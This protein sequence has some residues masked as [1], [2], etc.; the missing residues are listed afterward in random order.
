MTTGNYFQ[1]SGPAAGGQRSTGWAPPNPNPHQYIPGQGGYP[2][3]PYVT[4]RGHGV[5]GYHGAVWYPRP[6]AG[7]TDRFAFRP[8]QFQ[9]WHPV[10][11]GDYLVDE[12]GRVTYAPDYYRSAN[13]TFA[14]PESNALWSRLPPADRVYLYSWDDLLSRSEWVQAMA[15]GNI[16]RADQIKQD[17][18]SRH[19]AA[20]RQT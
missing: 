15:E 4:R 1:P 7:T 10:G 5:S 8:V 9:E 16:G 12:S 6:P 13:L 3:L 2:I 11:N 18:E 17:Y 14:T 19:R 20:R